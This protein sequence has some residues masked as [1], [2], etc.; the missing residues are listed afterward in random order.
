MV[1]C[2]HCRSS[3]RQTKH[4]KTRCGSQKYFCSLCRRSYTPH[5]K[6]QG[7]SPKVRQDAV[8]YS[9]E[10]LSQRKVARLLDVA[11]QSVANW[12]VQA[13]AKL[14]ALGVPEVPPELAQMADGVMEQDEVYTFCNAKRAKKDK[15][16]G[17]KKQKTRS[18]LPLCSHHRQP[19]DARHF[20]L[21]CGGRTH[22]QNDAALS[23]HGVFSGAPCRS[24]L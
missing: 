4:G 12:L 21:G 10:G 20:G 18:P 6:H 13:G 24:I 17:E 9:L 19:Q 3:Q 14:Q 1:S 11:P 15:K 7:R 22:H 16:T 5:P 2:P 23:R 8:R